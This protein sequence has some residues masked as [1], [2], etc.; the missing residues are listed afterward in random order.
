MPINRIRIKIDIQSPSA[1]PT[2][3][4]DPGTNSSSSGTAN[5]S[6]GATPGIFRGSYVR[7]ELAFCQDGAFLTNIS[8]FSAIQIGIKKQN[9]L[10]GDYD[11]GPYTAI[12]NGA[13]T[14]AQWIAGATA[15]AH[16]ILDLTPNQTSVGSSQYAAVFVVCAV[17]VSGNV[18]PL[19][20]IPFTVYPSG[21][22]GTPNLNNVIEQTAVHIRPKVPVQWQGSDGLWHTISLKAGEDGKQTFDISEIGQ[23]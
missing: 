21:A 2:N 3:I 15:N 20:V 11:S 8:D 22:T 18:N 5:Y 17:D 10:D 6:N 13:I 4:L 16:A 23:A 14:E 9:S 7:L 12:L 1:A 19:A